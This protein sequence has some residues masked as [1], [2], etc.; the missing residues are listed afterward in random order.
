MAS[1]QLEQQQIGARG[2]ITERGSGKS[3][4][5][6]TKAIATLQVCR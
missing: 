3:L 2:R 6:E 4:S 5:A 1:L